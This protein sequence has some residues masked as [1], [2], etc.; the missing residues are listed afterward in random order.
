MAEMLL[1]TTT[2]LEITTASGEKQGGT[3]FFYKIDRKDGRPGHCLLLIT[4]KHVVKDYRAL[5]FSVY[6]ATLNNQ[7]YVPKGALAAGF[8]DAR[9]VWFHHPDPTIDLCATSIGPFMK[10]L[11]AKGGVPFVH[12]FDEKLIGRDSD[13]L[14]LDAVENVLIVGY[15]AA[16]VAFDRFN[17]Y[18]IFR[19]GSQRPIPAWISAERASYSWMHQCFQARRAL[20]LS[21]SP[22]MSVISVLPF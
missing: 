4:N 19:R 20:Q 17:Y 5:R 22:A 16:S 8:I 14:E 3:G 1:Y 18:P 21:S 15:P 9:N 7:T 11:A 13:M 10:E 2:F 12:W 6:L